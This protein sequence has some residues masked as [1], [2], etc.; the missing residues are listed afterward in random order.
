MATLQ[1]PKLKKAHFM[2]AAKRLGFKTEM[3]QELTTMHGFFYRKRGS[4]KLT[5]FV[6]NMKVIAK[7]KG[8]TA[9]KPRKLT[10]QIFETLISPCGTYRMETEIYYATGLQADSHNRAMLTITAN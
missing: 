9:G 2:V 6:K 1:E 5:N 4:K 3:I 8:W 7:A 10:N